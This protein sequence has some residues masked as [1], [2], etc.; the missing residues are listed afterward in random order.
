MTQ[1]LEQLAQ[2]VRMKCKLQ[3]KSIRSFSHQQ[4]SQKALFPG[5][6]VHRH[7]TETSHWGFE[8][9]SFVPNDIHKLPLVCTLRQE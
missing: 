2:V 6:K 4:R 9:K 8:K 3:Q 7:G 5:F 1:C